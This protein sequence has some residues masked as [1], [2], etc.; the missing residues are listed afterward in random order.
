MKGDAWIVSDST[1]PRLG[2]RVNLMLVDSRAVCREGLCAVIEQESDL[3]VVAQAATVRDAG[4]SDVTPDVIITGIDTPDAT[5]CDV[6]AGLRMCFAESAILIF[7]RT[8]DPADVK[9][10]LAA[11][12]NGYLLETASTTELVTGIRAVARGETY[13]QP[14][15]G[16]QIARVHQPPD[17]M[18]V[19]SPEEEQVLRLLALG[20]TNTEVARLRGT[21]LRTAE[22]RRAHILRK[23]GRRTRAEL[24]EYT[25]KTG[26]VELARP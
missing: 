26:L 21:S 13:L 20:H 4:T 7:T 22:A 15:V 18:P 23:L 12:A 10:A 11:G 24:V 16:V 9:A 25:R 6:I 3:V 2:P 8:G 14:A 1:T 5:H 17:T 19:L